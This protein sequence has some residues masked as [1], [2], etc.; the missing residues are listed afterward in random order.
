MIPQGVRRVNAASVHSGE[1]REG[2]WAIRSEQNSVLSW[3]I[4][5]RSPSME[6]I[7]DFKWVSRFRMHW[8]S[9]IHSKH[10]LIL[11]DD[12]L[13]SLL[14]FLPSS[15]SFSFHWILLSLFL[16][17]FQSVHPDRLPCDFWLFLLFYLWISILKLWSMNGGWFLYWKWVGHSLSLFL[18]KR[19]CFCQS[20]SLKKAHTMGENSWGLR[21]G[22]HS[23]MTVIFRGLE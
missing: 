3:V 17:L 23:L 5:P 11:S 21:P 1:S 6:G 2:E 16:G 15:F 18:W 20:P 22:V 12:M 14:H 8:K 19:L 7:P 13:R 9:S 10:L 4:V